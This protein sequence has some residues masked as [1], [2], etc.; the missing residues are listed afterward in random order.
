MVDDGSTD[1]SYRVARNAQIPNCK[2]ISQKNSGAAIARNTGLKHASGDYIQFMD[3]D[4]YLSP[5]KIEKQVLAMLESPGK[6]AVC[7]YINFNQDSELNN[8]ATFPD[9]SEF[10]YS[11]NH[12]DEF[13]L[14]LWGANGSSNFIQTNSWLTPK[15]IIE[16]AG[17]WRNYRCPDDDGE[18]FTRVLL[19]SNG[20]IYV[21]KVYNFYRRSE[22]ENKLSS[23]SSKKYVHNTLLT[24]DLKYQYLK[25]VNQT[26]ALGRAFATQYFNFAVY[27]YPRHK[28]L[29]EIA[30]RRY[31]ELGERI[32]VPNI[33]GVFFQRLS[34][35]LG[36]KAARVLRYYLR[37]DGSFFHLPKR[38]NTGH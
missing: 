25:S 36:W 32:K 17:V 30:L 14:N 33:G 13:L 3:I 10:I 9:Q 22:S 19:A 12:P 20:I 7:N 31:T 35:A 15:S 27:A 11:S 18:F 6:V 5:D 37:E 28:I 34:D 4:D 26:Q 16:K 29:S 1:E 24:I 8:Q 23:N 21:P 38:F 2:V